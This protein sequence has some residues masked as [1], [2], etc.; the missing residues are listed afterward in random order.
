MIPIANAISNEILNLIILPTEACNFR[1]VYCYESFKIGKMRE[2]VIQG[3]KKLIDARASELKEL[4]ISWFGGEPLLALNVMEEISEHI[5][6]ISTSHPH[7]VFGANISTNGYFLDP[8]VFRKLLGWHVRTYQISFD[9]PKEL[10]DRKRI[11]ANGCGTFDKIW[12]NLEGMRLVDDDFGVIVRVHV[13]RLNY[14]HIPELLMQFKRSIGSDPRFKI[15]LRT[16]SCLGGP[17]DNELQVLEHLEEEPILNQLRSFAKSQRLETLASN[18]VEHVCYAAK[19][20]SFM[21]RATGSIG[22]CT[23]ALYDDSNDIGHLN[24]DGSMTLKHDKLMRWVRGLESGS[25]A[26]LACPLNNIGPAGDVKLR[27]L[28]RQVPT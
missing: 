19:L 2:P 18:P 3:I 23:V 28:I 9:G 15:Y 17:K 26:E 6:S 8:A 12:A 13:D 4:A 14:Q 22:K 7:L 1:C 27:R 10:H 24:S 11:L 25:R 16:L 20:N 21:V 5:L